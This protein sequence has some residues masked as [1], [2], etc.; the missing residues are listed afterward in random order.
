MTQRPRYVKR[1]FD[2]EIGYL[3]QSPCRNCRKRGNLPK[4]S[5]NCRVIDQ[6]QDLLAASLSCS[7]IKE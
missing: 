2:F 3:A 1:R 4:C 7:R 6:L 5:L